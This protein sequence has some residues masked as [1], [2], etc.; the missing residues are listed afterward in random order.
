M[1]KRTQLTAA[2]RESLVEGIRSHPSYRLAYVDADLLGDDD[3]RPARL[4]LELLKPERQLRLNH[5]G[6]TVVVFGSSCIA[7][8]RGGAWVLGVAILPIH[9]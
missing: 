5:M 8:G 6:S 4:Q 3:L 2:E 9:R 7:P 1:N